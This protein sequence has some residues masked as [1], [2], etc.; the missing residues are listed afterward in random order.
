MA[1]F[2]SSV[3]CISLVLSTMKNT[4][5]GTLEPPYSMAAIVATATQSETLGKSSGAEQDTHS[6]MARRARELLA[7]P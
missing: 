4:R 6:V 1:S 3:S 5:S 2:S 7:V